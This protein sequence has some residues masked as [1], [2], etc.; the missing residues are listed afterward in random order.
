MNEDNCQSKVKKFNSKTIVITSTS[1]LIKISVF[2]Y[3][4]EQAA[5]VN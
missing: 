2:I 3:V 5:V 4:L 1:E